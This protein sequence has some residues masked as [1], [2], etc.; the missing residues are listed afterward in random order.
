MRIYL[1]KWKRLLCS[2]K[3]DKEHHREELIQTNR[4][5]YQLRMVAD[6]LTFRTLERPTP[7]NR[8]TGRILILAISLE[9]YNLVYRKMLMLELHL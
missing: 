7:T 8:L 1:L 6:R 4:L 3:L 2:A 9:Q 5:R